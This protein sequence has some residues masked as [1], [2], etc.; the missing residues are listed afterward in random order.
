MTKV[1]ESAAAKLSVTMHKHMET[2][3]HRR[4]NTLIAQVRSADSEEAIKAQSAKRFIMRQINPDTPVPTGNNT[5]KVY[6]AK[7]KFP[8]ALAKK[9]DTIERRMKEVVELI[10]EVNDYVS[11]SNVELDKILV[12]SEKAK[13]AI[14]DAL[15]QRLDE[16][17]VNLIFQTQGDEA[18]QFI[19]DLP[20]YTDLKKLVKATGQRFLL[21]EKALH[22]QIGS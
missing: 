16:T 8:P 3:T 2:L 18:R 9:V 12:A 5:Y 22:L 20:N 21:E 7:S 10:V 1:K 19:N 6:K 15:M 11:A 17:L 14:V 4:F 13:R